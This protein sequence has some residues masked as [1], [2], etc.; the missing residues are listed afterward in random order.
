MLCYD[1]KVHTC[2]KRKMENFRKKY[3]STYQFIT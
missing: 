2:C 1:M 3:E